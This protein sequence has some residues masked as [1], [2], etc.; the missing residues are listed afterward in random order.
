MF[1][2]EK[3]WVFWVGLI[4]FGLACVGVFGVLWMLAFVT[5]SYGREFYVKFWTPFIVGGV[6]FI[7]I[8]FYMMRSGVKKQTKT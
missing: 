6:V 7:L 2:G 4:V 8:G 5:S 3:S 1:E